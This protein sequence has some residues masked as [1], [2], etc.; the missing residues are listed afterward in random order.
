MEL[1]GKPAS[2]FAMRRAMSF[3]IKGYSANALQLVNFQLDLFI[4]A[5]VAPTAEVVWCRPRTPEHAAGMGMRFL[6]LDRAA[7]QRLDD[8][9]YQG[10]GRA[11]SAS[12]PQ[13]EAR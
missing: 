6:A 10:A 1:C 4:L 7:A 5:A 8:Y 12:A 9:V 2:F 3:G 13:A 11:D